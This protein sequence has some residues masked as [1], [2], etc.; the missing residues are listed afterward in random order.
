LVSF[1]ASLDFINQSRVEFRPVEIR[2]SLAVMPSL[3]K[4]N[5]HCSSLRATIIH[6]DH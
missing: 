2:P 6:I 3:S 5:S 4:S 1:L